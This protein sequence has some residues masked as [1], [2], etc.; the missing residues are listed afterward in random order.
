MLISALLVMAMLMLLVTTYM[1]TS[2]NSPRTAQANANSLAGFM[3]AE[4]GMNMR[5]TEIRAKFVN[6][7]RPSGTSVT[8]SSKCAAGSG[9]FTCISYAIGN[10]TVTTFVYETTEKDASGNLVETGTV[11]PGETYA[12]L[13]YQQYAYRVVGSAVKD[14][15][16]EANVEMEFQSR[17]VPL[18]QFAAF[19]TDDL[20]I[21]PGRPMVLNGRVHTNK[22]L[23]LS[24]GVSLDITGQTTAGGEIRRV[25]KEN[26]TC[27]G[28]TMKFAGKDAPGC[29]T[30]PMTD[31][32]LQSYGGQV[33][34]RQP[35]LTVPSLDSL[36][37]D[38]AGLGGSELWSK[39]DVRVVWNT[40]TN[41][42]AVQRADGSEDTAATNALQSCAALT[43][44]TTFY[45]SR[46]A[47][48][49]TMM[50]VDQAKLLACIQSSG[51]F[52]AQDGKVLTMS[53]T[54]GGGLAIH[55]SFYPEGSDQNKY[56][57]RMKNGAA[58]GPAGGP[59]PK[60]LSIATNQPLYVQGDYN[61]AGNVPASLMGDTINVLSSAWVDG[62]KT[63]L[64]TVAD[65]ANPTEIH[66]AFLGGTDVTGSS[67]YNGGLEN[68][69]R[70]HE[71]W[72]AK[73]FKYVGSFV[74][75]GSPKKAKGAWSSAVYNAPDRNWSYDTLF[76]SADKLP[77]LTPRFVYLRQL[78]FAREF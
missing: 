78:F 11:A 29:F 28:G 43:Q 45:D 41:K 75:L 74:S 67:K 57:V 7:E 55:F 24:P 39:A 72:T 47:R 4:G 66:A 3:A 26:G 58:L 30:S 68:Y 27:N 6:Y 16:T 54:S 21:N 46:E 32:Q 77:P 53:D 5:A 62:K 18:F 59:A 71:N 14:S 69:P 22:D 70:F 19:Y 34:S 35:A 36:A 2:L 20:E 51:K 65:P 10:R 25:R 56:G 1:F 23:Y 12:G 49:I 61:V 73:E 64:T 33:K 17:L 60:G 48:Q 15:L 9:D 42:P 38:R 63:A 40:L 44:S 37:P 76:N 13:S 31:A 8:D 52:T 50:D